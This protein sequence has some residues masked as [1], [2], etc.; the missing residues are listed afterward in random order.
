MLFG[1]ISFFRKYLETA[2]AKSPERS[3]KDFSFRRS[4][5]LRERHITV[6]NCGLWATLRCS[7]LFLINVLKCATPR[8]LPSERTNREACQAGQV[9]KVRHKEHALLRHVNSV[10]RIVYS[11][12]NGYRVACRS[13]VCRVYVYPNTIFVYCRSLREQYN[14]P[15]LKHRPHDVAT[16]INPLA[17]SN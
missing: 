2:I 14:G 10:Y 6:I 17:T 8:K 7:L 9:N 1:T 15:R 12:L 16:R 5:P 3:I 11:L 13:Y 4:G